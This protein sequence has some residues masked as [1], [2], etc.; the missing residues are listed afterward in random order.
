MIRGAYQADR[1]AGAVTDFRWINRAEESGSE[2]VLQIKKRVCE[3][4]LKGVLRTYP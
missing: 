4:R 3:M 2:L 1:T